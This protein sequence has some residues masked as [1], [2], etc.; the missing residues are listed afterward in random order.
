[1]S[2]DLVIV[3]ANK[4]VDMAAFVVDPEHNTWVPLLKIWTNRLVRDKYWAIVY[5]P[6]PAAS[7]YMTGKVLGTGFLR[8]FAEKWDEV[9]FGM[10]VHKDW[11]KHGIGTLFLQYAYM[12][13]KMAGLRT[14]R[15]HVDPKN[16]CAVQLYF[17]QG[18][19]YQGSREDGHWILRKV[20]CE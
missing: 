9:V 7:G 13:A 8:G 3:D 20:I 12:Y 4:C 2:S 18:Y 15:L 6:I 5:G 19:R 11:G 17:A 16:E 1:M 10:V 14:L